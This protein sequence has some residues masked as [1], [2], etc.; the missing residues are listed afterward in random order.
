M[1]YIGITGIIG[2]GKSTVAEIFKCIGIPVYNADINAKKII[3]NNQLVKEELCKKYGKNIF[4][5][6]IL[7]TA[8][9][10]EIIFNSE[11]EKKYVNSI[12]HPIVIKDFYYWANHQGSDLVAIE[13]ALLTE[14][15]LS[16]NLNYVI[17]VSAKE[18]IR[19]KR[20]LKRDNTNLE[21]IKKK[22]AAQKDESEYKKIASFTILNNE[23][24]SLILQVRRIIEQIKEN[25]EI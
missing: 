16:N 6:N 25:H 24:N 19:I 3:N 14:V 21:T 4:I 13:S 8:L 5:N 22:I 1:I 17:N 12:V 9:L 7:N 23:S 11:N 15:D 18:E 2:S 20:L 10:S